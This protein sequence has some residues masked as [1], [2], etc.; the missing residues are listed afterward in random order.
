[1]TD[2]YTPACH[3]KNRMCKLRISCHQNQEWQEEIKE[4]SYKERSFENTSMSSETLNEINNFFRLVS[5]VDQKKL[6]KP[7][8]G[9]ENTE[10]KN[11]LTQIS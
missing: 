2:D 11:K 5:I 8:I 7:N 3:F 10:C 9:P 6:S 4:Q 1:M